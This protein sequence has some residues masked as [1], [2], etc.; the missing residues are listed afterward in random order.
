MVKG[1]LLSFLTYNLTNINFNK[2]LIPG[3]MLMR[4]DWKKNRRPIYIALI[5]VKNTKGYEPHFR[6][7]LYIV[8][9]QVETTSCTSQEC[10]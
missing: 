4:E 8:R 5:N 3:S 6:F 1:L 10:F 2:L 9:Y 7:L